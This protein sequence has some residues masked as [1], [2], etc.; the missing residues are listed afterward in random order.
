[1]ILSAK[2]EGTTDAVTLRRFLAETAQTAPNSRCLN[3]GTKHY[4]I[5]APCTDKQTNKNF[6]M[7][8]Q[9]DDNFQAHI[10]M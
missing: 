8:P 2:Q 4:T 10:A 7:T 3:G 1:M 6:K 9:T 5:E